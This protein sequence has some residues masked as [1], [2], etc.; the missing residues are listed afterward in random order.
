MRNFSVFEKI[1]FFDK[2]FLYWE[3]KLEK[4]WKRKV[5]VEQEGRHGLRSVEK[6]LRDNLTIYFIL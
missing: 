3:I 4:I 2:T 5:H 1:D 6:N